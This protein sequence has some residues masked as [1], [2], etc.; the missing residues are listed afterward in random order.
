[1]LVKFAARMATAVN[2]SGTV[3]LARHMLFLMGAPVKAKNNK[4]LV[5]WARAGKRLKTG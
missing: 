5:F 4:G 3:Q 1:M 2:H